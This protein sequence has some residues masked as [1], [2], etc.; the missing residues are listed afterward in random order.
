VSSPPRLHD[1]YLLQLLGYPAETALAIA[2][3]IFG[4]VL[5]RHDPLLCL[6]HGGG[7]LI[8]LGARLD[9]GWR[10]KSESGTI[11]H[12]PSDYLRRLCYDTAVFDPTLLGR[13][14]TDVGYDNVL[15][16]TDMPFDLADTDALTMIHSMDL[17]QESVN[18]ILG[19]NALRL[20]PALRKRFAPETLASPQP[21]PGARPDAE[22]ASSSE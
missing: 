10:R 3:L 9:L 17:P 11:P 18:A 5:D 12:P 7:C 1:Y 22:R 8:G 6:A 4:G 15:L 16:G 21:R 2:R 19:R 20:L 13:L 14:G